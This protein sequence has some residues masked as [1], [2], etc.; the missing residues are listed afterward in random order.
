MKYLLVAGLALL[1]A[2]DAPRHCYG[3]TRP[4]FTA[5][6]VT[7]SALTPA[8]LALDDPQGLLDPLV[9]DGTVSRVSD[10]LRQFETQPLSPEEARDNV[11]YGD[12]FEA[13]PRSCV[14]VKVAPDWRRSPCSGEQ[15][16]PCWVGDGPCLAKGEQPSPECPCSCRA[17]I[18]NQDVVVTTPDLRL[19]PAALVS[20][21]TDCDSPWSGRL[22]SCSSPNL[23][24]R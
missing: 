2:C 17:V 16:F 1:L 24:G 10:C 4:N 18:Q 8:G 22:K 7:A 13:G 11:C 9:V 14:V 3:T 15:V 21:A 20:L 19:F 6:V 23:V 12:H 5:Y